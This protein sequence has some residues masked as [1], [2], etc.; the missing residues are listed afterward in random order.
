MEKV[1]IYK[2]NNGFVFWSKQV[3]ICDSTVV[4]SVS[5]DIACLAWE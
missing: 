4:L 1:R 5:N 3:P 2:G